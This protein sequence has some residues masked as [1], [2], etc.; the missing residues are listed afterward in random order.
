M[1]FFTFS[2]K[3]IVTTFDYAI[4]IHFDKIGQKKR[5]LAGR[6]TWYLKKIKRKKSQSWVLGIFIFIFDNKLFVVSHHIWP[7]HYTR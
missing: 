4:L 5:S 7:A 3:I 1:A 2:N 6:Q